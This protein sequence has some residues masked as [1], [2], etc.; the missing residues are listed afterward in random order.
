MSVGDQIDRTGNL[1]KGI[2]ALIGFVPVAVLLFG[3]VEIPPSLSNLI[4]VLSFFIST[5]AIISIIMLRSSIRRFSDT[6]AAGIIMAVILLGSISAICYWRV[7]DKHVLVT[8]V[9]TSDILD[10]V[11]LPLNPSPEIQHLVEP[12]KPRN[13]YRAAKE[14]YRA[15][16]YTG[17]RGSEL[18]S[19]IEQENT[20]A[21]I[22]M[23]V[24]LVSA[25][26]L[27]VFGIVAGAWKIAEARSPVSQ[28]KS[29]RQRQ[30]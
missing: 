15:A 4:K 12:F 5:A 8:R 20:S 22:L 10:R 16:I 7:A 6:V 24:L 21:I 2:A 27:L 30:L 19:M 18:R 17:R 13:G 29:T 3:L 9:G 26:V 25:N 28:T 14:S 23:L 11:V 1:I